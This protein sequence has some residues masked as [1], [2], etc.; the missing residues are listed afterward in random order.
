MKQETFLEIYRKNGELAN[1]GTTYR[2]ATKEENY[3]ETQIRDG[4][5]LEAAIAP[6]RQT[7]HGWC[8][9]TAKISNSL[10]AQIRT[11]D[12]HF[13]PHRSQKCLEKLNL[14][15]LSRDFGRRDFMLRSPRGTQLHP[16]T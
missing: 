3:R 6:K 15:P 9:A 16:V 11:S 12:T 4:W 8:P 7:R 14:E 2:F 10:Q 13:K 5:V 1:R